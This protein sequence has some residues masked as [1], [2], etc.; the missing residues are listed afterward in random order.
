MVDDIPQGDCSTPP[1]QA[2]RS[3]NLA[4]IEDL[5]RLA[6]SGD[7]VEAMQPDNRRAPSVRVTGTG[8]PLLAGRRTREAA[9]VTTPAAIAITR[10][11]TRPRPRQ[12][13]SGRGA[14]PGRERPSRC[15]PCQRPGQAAR[16]QAEQ[17]R[18]GGM[19][20]TAEIAASRPLRAGRASGPSSGGGPSGWGRRWNDARCPRQPLGGGSRGES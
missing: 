16:Q 4:P 19:P 8:D 9:H 1:E 2:G 18:V 12:R 20:V 15:R 17:Q 13:P 7:S 6:L 3:R 14:P 10:W 5:E 11:C